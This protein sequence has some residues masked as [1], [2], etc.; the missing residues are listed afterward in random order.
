MVAKSAL[1]DEGGRLTIE[2][3]G[4]PSQAI[5]LTAAVLTLGRSP[6]NTLPLPHSAVSRRHAE[7]ATTPDGTA[8]TD[9]GSANG[10]VVDGVPLREHQPR[11]LTH[12]AVI[13]IGPFVLVYEDAA[14]LRQRDPRLG[15]EH[16]PV[17]A[18][19][20]RAG[21]EAGD[22]NLSLKPGATRAQTP[23]SPVWPAAE[24]AR[25]P[26][27][28]D[29][30]PRQKLPAPLAPAGI[31]Q[32]LQFLPVIFQ[33]SDFLGRFLLIMESLWEPLEER[34]AHIEAYFDPAMC[35]V[36]FLPWLMSWIDPALDTHWPEG[37]VRA[38]LAE[39]MDLYRWRGTRYGVAR[40]IEVCTGLTPLVG[41]D[42]DAPFVFHVRLTIPAGAA[43]DGRLVEGLIQ[44]QKPAHAG[45]VLDMTHATGIQHVVGTS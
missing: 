39:A 22:A 20:E 30:A 34:H 6:D 45:Y 14:S 25:L 29:L 3:Q 12:G 41:E 42:A 11:R 43:V 31:S 36:E 44:S 26:A 16:S 35:P 28:P 21:M 13:Q 17:R 8:I 19:A 18:L 37:R 2:R 27:P 10:T 40:M 4:E 7:L 5:N 24:G 33:D 38:L 23:S 15:G 9:L 1:P 32:Y